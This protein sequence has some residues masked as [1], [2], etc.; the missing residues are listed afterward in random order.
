[1]VRSL[2]YLR[3]AKT[4]EDTS[5]SN[6]AFDLQENARLWR[7]PKQRPVFEPWEINISRIPLGAMQQGPA[8]PRVDIAEPSLPPVPPSPSVSGLGSLPL[9]RLPT[10]QVK[11]MSS[12]NVDQ[13]E[14]SCQSGLEAYLRLT[15]VPWKGPWRMVNC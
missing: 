15:E 14:E 10:P 7:P 2:E 3:R 6:L 9:T 5:T 11:R 12:P 13:L 1:M 8:K 4:R